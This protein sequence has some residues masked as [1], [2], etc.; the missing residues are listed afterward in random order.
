[1]TAVARCSSC[2]WTRTARTERLALDALSFHGA[3]HRPSEFAL[4]R[5]FAGAA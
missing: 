2:P 4:D 5:T 1:M 3:S